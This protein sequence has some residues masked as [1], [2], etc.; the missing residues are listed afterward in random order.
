MTKFSLPLL[1]LAALPVAVVAA[2][3]DYQFSPMALLDDATWV[4][5]MNVVLPVDVKDCWDIITDDDALQFWHPELTMVESIKETPGTVGNVRTVVYT[6]WLLDIF[7]LGAIKLE[8]TF[9]VWEED[10]GDIKTF[11]FWISGATRPTYFSYT[12]AREEWTCEKYSSGKS[13]F[14]RTLA[15]EPGAVTA[16]LGFVVYPKLQRTFEVMCP[17]RLLRSI[18]N[19]DLPIKK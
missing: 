18:E 16:A 1:L 2:F 6:D 9:D 8:E 7:V 13:I 4:F 15:F 19:G 3:F 17:K 10:E 12:M 11:Q 14:R 5:D